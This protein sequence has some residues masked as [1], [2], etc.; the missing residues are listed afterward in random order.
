MKKPHVPEEAYLCSSQWKKRKLFLSQSGL[1]EVGRPNITSYWLLG[2]H[3]RES[4]F[5]GG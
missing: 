5:W 3:P 1:R 4:E 2:D